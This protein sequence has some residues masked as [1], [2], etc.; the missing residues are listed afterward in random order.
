ME[1]KAPFAFFAPI[2]SRTCSHVAVRRAHATGTP[3][4]HSGFQPTGWW[5]EG[6]Q[7]ARE[8]RAGLVLRALPKAIIQTRK[9]MRNRFVGFVPHV[10]ETERFALNFAVAGIDDEVMFLS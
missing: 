8:L 6:K 5:L 10:G 7:P 9:Q 4:G 2:P 3:A 1:T